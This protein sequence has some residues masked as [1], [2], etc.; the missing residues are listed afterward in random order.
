[1]FTTNKISKD[2]VAVTHDSKQMCIRRSGRKYFGKEKCV[3]LLTE[4]KLIID[5]KALD[6]FG[7]ELKIGGD[8]KWQ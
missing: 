5:K 7:L 4:G 2:L 8:D 1:M 3:A 6:E